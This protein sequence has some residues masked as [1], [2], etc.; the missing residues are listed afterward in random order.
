L[1]QRLRLGAGLLQGRR[2]LG[3]GFRADGGRLL[4]GLRQRLLR[5]FLGFQDLVDDFLHIRPIVREF[6]P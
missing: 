3:V 1:Q 2:G 6:I 4:A 5:L